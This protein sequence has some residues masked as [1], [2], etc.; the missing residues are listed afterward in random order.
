[1]C[2]TAVSSV[3][4]PMAAGLNTGI[5]MLVAMPFALVGAVGMGVYLARR[6]GRS[7]ETA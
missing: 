3:D 1:M 2:K 5:L 6:A 7:K 4:D